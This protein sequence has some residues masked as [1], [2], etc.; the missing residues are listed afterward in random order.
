MSNFKIN[1]GIYWL[2][3]Q[4]GFSENDLQFIISDINTDTVSDAGTIL[5]RKEVSH[6]NPGSDPKA[7]QVK[8]LLRQ[9]Y[10]QGYQ[11]YDFGFEDGTSSFMLV[12][13]GDAWLET[14]NNRDVVFYSDPN[15]GW[16][17]DKKL[18]KFADW[19]KQEGPSSNFNLPNDFKL[20]DL[21]Q[22]N[23]FKLQGTYFH[24][25]EDTYL[26]SFEHVA[27]FLNSLQNAVGRPELKGKIAENITY[28][29]DWY[30]DNRGDWTQ[31]GKDG[32]IDTFQFRL[33]TSLLLELGQIGGG[34]QMLGALN[35]LNPIEWNYLFRDPVFS[36]NLVSELEVAFLTD[37]TALIFAANTFNTS[38][39]EMNLVL[40]SALVKTGLKMPK[41]ILEKASQ[42]FT[43]F[44]T[45]AISSPDQ[46]YPG[47]L[48]IALDGFK[49][50]LG[51]YPEYQPPKELLNQIYHFISG[52]QTI[53][54]DKMELPTMPSGVSKDIYDEDRS[55][56]SLLM[57]VNLEIMTEAFDAL[58]LAGKDGHAL[59]LQIAQEID[60]NGDPHEPQDILTALFMVL[61]EE[62]PDVPRSDAY[63]QFYKRVL[64]RRMLAQRRGDHK[65]VAKL[66]QLQTMNQIGR[67][68]ERMFWGNQAFRDSFL[69]GYKDIF[70]RQMDRNLDSSDHL[71]RRNFLPIAIL[72]SLYD[73]V[74][75]IGTPEQKMKQEAID[76]KNLIYFGTLDDHSVDEKT[77]RSQFGSNLAAVIDIINKIQSGTINLDD[78][79]RHHLGKTRYDN[80]DNSQFSDFIQQADQEGLLGFI[81]ETSDKREDELPISV[82]WQ[83]L[84]DTELNDYMI[85]GKDARAQAIS[86]IFTLRSWS[87]GINGRMETY[88]DLL[89]ANPNPN[90][91]SVTEKMAFLNGFRHSDLQ[92]L[93]PN[94]LISFFD[95]PNELV[96]ETAF[97]IYRDQGYP[98]AIARNFIGIHFGFSPDERRTAHNF[99]EALKAKNLRPSTVVIIADIIGAA[100]SKATTSHFLR[101]KNRYVEDEIRL[102][103]HMQESQGIFRMGETSFSKKMDAL[104][105]PD[106]DHPFAYRGLSHHL[107]STGDPRVVPALLDAYLM[108]DAPVK[109]ANRPLYPIMPT[110]DTVIQIF[111]VANRKQ[112]EKGLVN[113]VTHSP[114]RGLL[115]GLLPKLLLDWGRKNHVDVVRAFRKAMFQYDSGYNLEI[116]E[117]YLQLQKEESKNTA[118]QDQ[119]QIDQLKEDLIGLYAK[120]LDHQQATHP[121]AIDQLIASLYNE[122]RK[123][124]LIDEL[125]RYNIQAIPEVTRRIEILNRKIDDPTIADPVEREKYQIQRDQLMEVLLA[126]SAGYW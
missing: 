67:E 43:A 61:H 105:T 98:S 87:S 66:D 122:A 120:A 116:E 20:S 75:I 54:K 88:F 4:T 29:R 38:T 104:V 125:A 35:A 93:L 1:Q 89:H 55:V 101:G 114:K 30:I 3:T 47:E 12:D 56:K 94:Y 63:V 95:D 96:Q 51:H 82:F 102:P 53:S 103:K 60:N 18:E 25:W 26:F 71:L 76:S 110:L 64:A 23:I 40:L 36:T 77:G 83:L 8:E 59:K 22:Q 112:V 100:S 115:G 37:P 33:G 72:Q 86:A 34:Q 44:L 91:S 42:A 14:D 108:D 7:I 121:E 80:G 84:N 68:L 19:I 52:F 27:G 16:V 118:D 6:F 90:K 78:I 41:V 9:W 113:T 109:V 48:L 57:D 92:Y 119:H 73:D 45:Q 65:L 24:G 13:D 58:E 97:E 39:S 46:I 106:A 49:S 79:I 62:L 74:D 117:K 123:Q 21:N 107:T 28:F 10:D 11:I 126:I 2:E 50:L 5:S 70:T 31:P 69:S 15:D 81:Q 32:R 111:G 85:G 124:Y 17:Q 99:M